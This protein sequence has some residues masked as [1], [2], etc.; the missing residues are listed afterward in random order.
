MSQL[1]CKCM[2]FNSFGPNLTVPGMQSFY[3]ILNYAASRPTALLMHGFDLKVDF[4]KKTRLKNK[5]A[6]VCAPHFFSITTWLRMR[7]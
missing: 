7:P 2:G 5:M 4:L 6:D 1:W 3:R